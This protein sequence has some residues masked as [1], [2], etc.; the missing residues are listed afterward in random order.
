MKVSLPQH[1]M[2]PVEKWGKPAAIDI[3]VGIADPD[4]GPWY[5]LGDRTGSEDE[6]HKPTNWSEP[7]E[8]VLRKDE[9]FLTKLRQNVKSYL[10]NV[11]KI[12][13]H[14]PGPSC[15]RK[16]CPMKYTL[17]SVNIHWIMIFPVESFTQ[18]WKNANIKKS[19]FR[20]GWRRFEQNWPRLFK[21]WIALSTG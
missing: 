10:Y 4:V 21:R 14:S 15:L 6:P 11:T 2:K 19:E 5:S 12:I 20:I 8:R 3:S 18:P 17:I 1:L 16:H 7:R 13:M 9:P